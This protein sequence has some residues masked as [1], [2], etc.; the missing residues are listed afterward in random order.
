VAVVADFSLF[1]EDVKG[2]DPWVELVLTAGSEFQ[3]KGRVFGKSESDVRP[4]PRCAGQ[5]VGI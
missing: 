1:R 4:N 5:P 3:A 2:V